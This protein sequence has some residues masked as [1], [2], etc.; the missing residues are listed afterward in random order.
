MDW[1]GFSHSPRVEKPYTREAGKAKMEST[2][3]QTSMIKPTLILTT[4]LFLLVAPAPDA[5]DFAE[6]TAN[7]LMM[8]DHSGLMASAEPITPVRED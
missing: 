4:L 8:D 5:N 1:K 7:F 6:M 2:R 3:T